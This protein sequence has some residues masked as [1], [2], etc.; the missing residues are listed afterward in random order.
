[1]GI[2]EYIILKK[3]THF[4]ISDI[5]FEIPI[6]KHRY[7]LKPKQILLEFHLNL[8]IAITIHINLE[9]TTMA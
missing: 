2:Q 6:P 8:K 3:Y 5:I 4:I 1:M 9:T 7:V